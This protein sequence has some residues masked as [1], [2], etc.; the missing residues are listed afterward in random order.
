MKDKQMILL[1]ETMKEGFVYVTD[2]I[3]NAMKQ[4]N[5]KMSM[6]ISKKF[7]NNIDKIAWPINDNFKTIFNGLNQID[8]TKS[9]K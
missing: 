5:E 1:S 7:S 4:N 3:I 8:G 9:K 2:G 6:D